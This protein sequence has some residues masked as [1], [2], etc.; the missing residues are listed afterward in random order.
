MKRHFLPNET[1]F[2]FDKTILSTGRNKKTSQMNY[3]FWKV[4]LYYLF[5]RNYIRREYLR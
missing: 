5:I 1:V 4:F 3:F 2:S